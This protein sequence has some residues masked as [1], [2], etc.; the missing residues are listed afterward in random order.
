MALVCACSRSVVLVLGLYMHN[1][2]GRSITLMPADRVGVDGAGVGSPG[3]LGK[4][5]HV[6]LGVGETLSTVFA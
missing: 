3:G 4:A 1:M 5:G 2:H 6:G